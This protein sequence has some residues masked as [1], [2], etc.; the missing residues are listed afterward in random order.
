[1]LRTESRGK[2][3]LEEEFMVVSIALMIR[4]PSM[5]SAVSRCHGRSGMR[6]WAIRLHK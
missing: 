6:V 4:L 1:L 3:Y 2:Q 5:S